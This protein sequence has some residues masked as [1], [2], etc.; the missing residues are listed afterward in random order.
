V[1]TYATSEAAAL[2]VVQ[3]LSPFTATN[4]SRG[5]FRVLDRAG[6]TQAA[7]IT[8]ARASENG[9]DLGQGRGTQGKR[10]QRHWLA[11]V[12]FQARGQADDG[13]SYTSLTALTDTLVAHLDKY[14][15]LN[16]A[17]SVKR[18]QVREIAEPRLSARWS[19]WL[20]QTILVEVMTET[21]PV[22][23]SGDFAR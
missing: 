15:R 23:T 19:A 18:A 12:V 16:N 2:A 7:V 14:Q 21:S 3:L 9:D 1:S 13:T 22:V 6:V 4:A 8:Q 11:I 20:F 17:T 10:Q 5:D